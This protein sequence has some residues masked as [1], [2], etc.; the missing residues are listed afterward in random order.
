MA[1]ERTRSPWFAAGLRFECQPDCGACC[2]NHGE[3]AYVYLSDEEARRLGAFLEL[4]PA[5]FR[6][7]YTT[8]DEGEL[9]LRMDQPACPFLDGTRCGVYPVRP[10]QCRSFPFWEETLASRAQWEALR[11]FCPGIGRGELQSAERILL[12]LA[13]AP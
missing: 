9:V 10:R 4:E 7:R 2:V 12:Q 6:A 8:L 11:E 5:E 3:Y 13:D 1:S